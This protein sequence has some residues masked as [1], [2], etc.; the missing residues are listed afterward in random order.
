MA[1][2]SGNPLP[3]LSAAVE[4]SI[5]KAGELDR[6]RFHRS[7]SGNL[8]CQWRKYFNSRNQACYTFV[9]GGS[10][11]LPGG[12]ISGKSRRATPIRLSAIP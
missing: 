1:R 11:T 3:A 4:E 8:P 12:R 7:L 6:R 9:S 2:D 10:A 5:I